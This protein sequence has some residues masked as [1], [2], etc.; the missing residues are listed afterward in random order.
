VLL[1]EL[2]GVVF[3]AICR[4]FR[5][6][7]PDVPLRTGVYGSMH[8]SRRIGICPQVPH[9]AS[10]YSSNTSGPGRTIYI[11]FQVMDYS[12]EPRV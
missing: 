7:V 9:E 8:R 12:D 3:R 5:R 4:S 11:S 10:P 6:L 1:S 2:F